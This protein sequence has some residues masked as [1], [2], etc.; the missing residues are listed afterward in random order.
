[1]DSVRLAILGALSASR[2]GMERSELLRVLAEAGVRAADATR[3][4]EAL[5][6]AGSL[7]LR[8]GRLEL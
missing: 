7:G 3:E 5:R 2:V 8:E 4:L 6:D 1:M